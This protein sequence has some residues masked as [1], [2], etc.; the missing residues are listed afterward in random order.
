MLLTVEMIKDYLERK[1]VRVSC[2]FSADEYKFTDVRC[3]YP[4]ISINQEYLYFCRGTEKL[5]GRS[6]KIFTVWAVTRPGRETGGYEMECV[7][8]E[9]KLLDL[10]SECF[11]WYRSWY[12]EMNECLLNGGG[13]KRLV[14]IG[15]RVFNNPIIIDDSSFRVLAFTGEYQ[16]ELCDPESVFLAEKGYHSPEYVSRIMEDPVFLKNMNH[17]MEPFVHHYEFLE[18]ESM[19]CPIRCK[20]RLSGFLTIVGL[21]GSFTK[22]TLHAAKIFAEAAARMFYLTGQQH[23]QNRPEDSIFL[24][25]LNRNLMD[26]ELIQVCLNKSG[27]TADASYY[28]V[29][30]VPMI[31]TD[32]NYF[33]L[34]RLLELLKER[35]RKSRVLMDD[36]AIIMIVNE[37]QM[38]RGKLKE[39]LREWI[40]S[41]KFA[42]GMSLSF[43]D[44]KKLPYFYT[45]AERSVFW[46]RK[47]KPRDNLF[48]YTDILP[49]DL[50]SRNINQ[51]EKPSLLHPA[52]RKLEETD[53]ERKSELKKTLLCYLK[54]NGNRIEAA[55][56]L[57]VH[58]NSLYYR[59]NQI[60][61]LTGAKLSDPA[62]LEHL[63]ISCILKDIDDMQ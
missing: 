50:L 22:G 19:Y 31:E 47:L 59:L 21:N 51:E 53:A 10:I 56:E 29:R 43:Q 13:L 17:N 23:M 15:Q 14:E 25:L 2:G 28:A 30:L 26:Q 60:E 1:G 63:R 8:P 33:V 39:L 36:S 57:H 44:L 37:E 62:V 32:S 27:L 45:Q 3:Y 20:K 4:E 18:H 61:T 7:C 42:V 58:K 54:H 35:I 48:S 49:Y 40:Q 11:C 24:D 16:D 46:G 12:L 9:E 6:D 38:T 55:N 41:H 52:I 34:E 5:S